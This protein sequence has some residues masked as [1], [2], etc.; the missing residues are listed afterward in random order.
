MKQEQCKNLKKLL[1]YGVWGGEEDNNI[2]NKKSSWIG[3]LIL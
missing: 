2:Q 1:K 3:K